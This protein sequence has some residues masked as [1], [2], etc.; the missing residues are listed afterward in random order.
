MRHAPL[1][2]VERNIR[3]V[4]YQKKGAGS[5]TRLWQVHFTF[6][7][8]PPVSQSFSDSLFR[9]K[10]QALV[11][12]QRF[13]DAME[14]E[15]AASEIGYG[16]FGKVDV[17]PNHGISRSFNDRITKSGSR[18]HWFWQ[19][20]WPG[21]EKKQVNRSFYD[22][23]CGGEGGAKLAAR[24]ARRA[25]LET[26]LEDLRAGRLPRMKRAED[27]GAYQAAPYTLFMPP[28]N[29][30]NPVWRYMD[31]T[32]YV[33]MLENGGVFLPTVAMLE[34]RFE[35]SY[36]RGNQELRPMIHKHMA[37]AFGLTAG[38]MVQRLREHVAVSCWHM[39]ERESAAMWRLYARTD[40]AVCVQTTF[41]KLREA[42][43]D[44]ARA[45]MVRYVD[46]ETGWIPESHPLAPFLYKRKSFEHE[47]EVRAIVAP[48][49]ME[50]LLKGT[51]KRK[52]AAGQWVKLP[53]AETI[54]KVLVAP[55]APAWF[56]E[57]VRQVT[58]KYEHGAVPVERSALA[59]QP[60][61]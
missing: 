15:F 61:Y 51:R 35:G 54:E 8:R 9:G 34:D 21:P 16:K 48:A 12:A 20:T 6:K 44:I 36:G 22:T 58:A 32:K 13:R 17:D 31:F 55:D 5:W 3:R 1:S 4:D 53:V 24:E 47:R 52:P 11:V 59:Q 23:K 38:E 57:L 42:M 30:D 27:E 28:V 46:Y 56:L 40:E 14:N 33:S 7:G 2:G 45:G 39:N 10:E 25:G 19:A 50:A 41:R 49:G 26:Y 29:S 43:G 18:R 60:I 37:P